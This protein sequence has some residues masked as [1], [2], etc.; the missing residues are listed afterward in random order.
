MRGFHIFFVVIPNWTSCYQQCIR[1]WSKALWH[2]TYM[3]LLWI[4]FM[5]K[6]LQVDK[7]ISTHIHARTA[8]AWNWWW[9]EHIVIGK[10]YMNRT[11]EYVVCLLFVSLLSHFWLIHFCPPTPA[12]STISRPFSSSMCSITPETANVGSSY[13]RM[14]GP[15]IYKRWLIYTN[16]HMVCRKSAYVWLATMWL[17]HIEYLVF[18]PEWV[19]PSSTLGMRWC[20]TA[21]TSSG[22]PLWTIRWISR[23]EQSQPAHRDWSISAQTSRWWVSGYT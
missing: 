11:T 17:F 6:L 7:L 9:K 16:L 12:L 18:Y 23:A 13:K 8:A 19:W 14:R 20:W 10:A 4:S 2:V 3:Y 15:G 21:M 22:T 1:P 5:A